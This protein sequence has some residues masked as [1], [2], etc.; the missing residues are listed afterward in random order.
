MLWLRNTGR[1]L[2]TKKRNEEMIYLAS[3]YF[4]PDPTVRQNRFDMA[5]RA[6]AHLMRLGLNVFSPIA[7]SHSIARYGLPVDWV[8]WERLDREYLTFCERMIVLKIPGWKESR[9]VTKEIEIMT[10]SGKPILYYNYDADNFMWWP[11]EST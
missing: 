11:D 10:E 8:F 4:D 7:H 2:A 6:A 5:C 9:G 3:P 1:A